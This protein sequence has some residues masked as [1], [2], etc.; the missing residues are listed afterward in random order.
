MEIKI[1]QNTDWRFGEYLKDVYVLEKSE[2]ESEFPSINRVRYD[3]FNLETNE[4]IEILP[5]IEKYNI[6]EIINVSTDSDYIYFTNLFEADGNGTVAIIRYNISTKETESVYSYSESIEHLNV[7]KRLKL[8]VLNDLYLIL[9]NEYLVQNQSQTYA[10]F[11]KF[12]LKMYNLKDRTEYPVTD[13]N[14]TLNGISDMIPVSETQAVIKTGF[15][16]LED[17]RYNALDEEE[18]SLEALSFINISQ[19]ISDLMIDYTSLSL[20]TIEQAYYTKT[21]S[22]V[23]KCK[24]Y[25]IYSCINNETKE[26]EVKFYNLTTK[27]IKSCI[28]QEVIRTSDL[29]NPYIINAEPYICIMKENTISFLNLNTNKIDFNNDEGLVL[30]KVFDDTILFSG[31]STALLTKKVK[32]YFDIIS[33]PQGNLLHH[34]QN[35]YVDSFTDDENVLYIIVK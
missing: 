18:C 11:F 27:E 14:F 21:I 20:E 17:N 15:S 1:L 25:L 30:R 3:L 28:N 22:Y 32:P 34:E 5:N 6:G 16:L 4:R 7:T 33:F 29:A 31:V 24:N 10:G 23:K 13:E 2:W 19:M 8:F 26:E 35:E 9:Q 12:D